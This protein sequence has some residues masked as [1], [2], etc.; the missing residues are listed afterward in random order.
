MVLRKSKDRAISDPLLPRKLRA[1][2][3]LEDISGQPTFPETPKDHYL[4][5]Y[6]EAID[7]IV[8]AMEHRFSQPS[9]AAFEK[10]ESLL[11]KDINGE[12][13]TAE[14]DY[15]KVSYNDDNNFDSLKGQL[16]VLRQILKDKGAMEC[17]DDVLCEV[18]KLPKEE[19][20]LIGEV[21][22]LCKLLAINPAT[23][24]CCERSFFSSTSPEDMAEIERETAA[25]QQPDST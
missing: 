24:A 13:Y 3:R 15:M 5:I 9:S 17:F 4:R 6:F 8:N 19:Q 18:K 7:L 16:Q 25:I 11:L 14:L 2:V 22:I 10:I 23:S 21:V 20:S 12:S 1:P